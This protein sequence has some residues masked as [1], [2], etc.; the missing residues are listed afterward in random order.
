LYLGA[1][2]ETADFF[3]HDLTSTPQPEI[4]KVLVTGATGYIGGR[5]VPELL[6]RGYQVRVLVRSPSEEYQDRWP[7]AEIVVADALKQET[8]RRALDKIHTAYY[9][10]HSLYL[11]PKEFTAADI[12]LPQ[13]SES[14]LNPRESN[15]SSILAG[16]VTSTALCQNT[17]GVE[18]R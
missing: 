12:R 3:C 10:I 13:T 18:W 5:L 16:L 1:D 2:V 9:L 11:G 15:E 8:L 14:L 6:A 4:G 17:C 7:G